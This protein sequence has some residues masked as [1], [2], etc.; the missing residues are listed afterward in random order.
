MVNGYSYSY[1]FQQTPVNY[2]YVAMYTLVY[3]MYYCGY[4]YFFQINCNT[5]LFISLSA[6]CIMYYVLCVMF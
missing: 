6:R 4:N 1:V 2:A 3:I 5:K